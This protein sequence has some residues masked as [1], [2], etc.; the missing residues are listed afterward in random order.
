MMKNS[1]SADRSADLSADLGA[2][3]GADSS[4]C[5]I[6]RISLVVETIS[7]LLI[8]GMLIACLV[9]SVVS[10]HI[11]EH[12]SP[13]SDIDRYWTTAPLKGLTALW[14]IVVASFGIGVEL[15]LAPLRIITLKC[16]GKF[17]IIFGVLDIARYIQLTLAVL[18]AFGLYTGIREEYPKFADE[19]ERNYPGEPGCDRVR[20]RGDDFLPA[21]VITIVT[22]VVAAAGLS[23]YR[24]SSVNIETFDIHS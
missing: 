22:V 23:K 18:L 10:L 11:N 5:T 2:D 14:T 8:M 15:I 1:S 7:K 13:D 12:V 6:L 16:C 24:K 3:L 19:C 17:T 9:V 20:E 4:V 21:V